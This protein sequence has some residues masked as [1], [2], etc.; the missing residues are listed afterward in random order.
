MCV[1]PHHSFRTFEWP[2][3]IAVEY[4]FFLTATTKYY[5]NFHIARPRA[6]RILIRSVWELWSSVWNDFPMALPAAALADMVWLSGLCL[7]RNRTFRKK[8]DSNVLSCPV[9]EREERERK[10]EI[11]ALSTVKTDR[12]LKSLAL[13]LSA[14]SIALEKVKRIKRVNFIH[15]LS[16]KRHST[17]WCRYIIPAARLV[18]VDA[19]NSILYIGSLF[20]IAQLGC[21]KVKIWF[22]IE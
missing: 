15:Y 5:Y 16:M 9:R 7:T 22:S 6:Y 11:G 1:A 18:G 17:I 4:L 2:L 13:S 21:R 12:K 14:S 3:C 8:L 19:K 20:H 10:R